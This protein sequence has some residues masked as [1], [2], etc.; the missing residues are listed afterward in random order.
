MEK[1]AAK[2]L[3]TRFVK[4]DAEKSNYLVEKLMVV[5]MPTILLVKDGKVVHQIQGENLSEMKLKMF[6]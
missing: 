5:V 6:K 2:H 3:E 1:L 4:I